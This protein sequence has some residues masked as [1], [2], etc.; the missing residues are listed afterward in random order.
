MN[1]VAANADALPHP[2]DETSEL[3]NNKENT[4]TGAWMDPFAETRKLGT[5]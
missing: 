2:G 3:V 5:C 1:R 4:S